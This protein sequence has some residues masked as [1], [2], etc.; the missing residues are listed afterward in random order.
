MKNLKVIL[1]TLALILGIGSAYAYKVTLN[2]INGLPRFSKAVQTETYI[3]E[4]ALASDQTISNYVSISGSNYECLE[5]DNLVCTYTF[6]VNAPVGQRIKQ[7]DEGMY[8]SG[9]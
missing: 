1:F 7:C 3:A 5:I 9:D 8:E 2:C 6:D 4:G